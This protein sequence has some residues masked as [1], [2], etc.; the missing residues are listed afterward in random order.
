VNYP[1]RGYYKWGV[2][3]FEMT[4]KLPM[5]ITGDKVLM[6]WR[7]VTGNSCIPPGYLSY[8]W[9]DP[10][11]LGGDHSPCSYPLDPTGARCTGC[12][13]QFWNC[14]EIT[15]VP[16]N[17]QPI[18]PPPSSAPVQSPVTS[19]VAGPTSSSPSVSSGVGCC[20]RD[21]KNCNLQLEGWCSE[22]KE[23][24]EGAC[25][26]FWL[27]NGAIEGCTARY[28][29]CSSTADCCGPLSCSSGQC[30][31]SSTPTTPTPVTS[32]PT[33]SPTVPEP[34]YSINYK[35]CLPAAASSNDQFCN[36]VWLPDGAQSNCVALGGDCS[37]DSCC[38]PAECFVGSSAS[39]CIP[40]TSSPTKAPTVSP[41]MA[42]ITSSLT[43]TSPSCVTCDD[44]A[45]PYMIKKGKQ[46]ATVNLNAK[47]TN[48]SNW[49]DNKW[50]RLSCYE[51]G[52]AYEGEVCCNGNL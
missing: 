36:K 50:C 47:C 27:P 32:S 13:E 49:I 22:S 31:L 34:C 37:W 35:D 25:M 17:G 39:I 24:C 48:N 23:N 38:G 44:I 6:Q 42:P 8:P 19:P 14:A 9:P 2:Q 51:V 18:S 15:I 5:G 52:L 43:P 12:P 41:T 33:K 11:W 28:E 45:S 30:E 29:A 46:C 21:F 10:S 4:F 16:D 7:Y 40:S 3:D 26:K 20:S 1:N